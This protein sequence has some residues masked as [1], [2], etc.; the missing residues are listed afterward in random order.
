MSFALP[1]LLANTHD[2]GAFIFF[3]GWCGLSIVYVYLV[4]P[5]VSGLSVEE[6]DSL[7]TGPWFSAYKQKKPGHNPRLYDDEAN[8]SYEFPSLFLK[9][10]LLTYFLAVRKAKPVLIYESRHTTAQKINCVLLYIFSEIINARLEQIFS[11]F[12]EATIS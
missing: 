8:I 12:S 2:W 11:S 5:E 3:A 4:V 6:L 9:H 7:F 1:S 10:P